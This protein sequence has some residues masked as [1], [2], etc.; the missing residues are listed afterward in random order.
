MDKSF[1]LLQPILFFNN[2][3]CI[4]ILT[5][6]GAKF[7]GV[8]PLHQMNLDRKIGFLCPNKN[9]RFI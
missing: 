1:I 6:Y 8:C 5:K 3:A 2:G 4:K 7:G 9:K